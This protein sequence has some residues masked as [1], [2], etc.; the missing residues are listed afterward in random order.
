MRAAELPWLQPGRAAE[1]IIGGDVAGW[2]GE[3]APSRSSVRSASCSC[4][5]RMRVRIYSLLVP[6]VKD[7]VYQ[8]LK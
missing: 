7:S 5:R 4:S 2:I 8:I 1:I 6:K 3:V